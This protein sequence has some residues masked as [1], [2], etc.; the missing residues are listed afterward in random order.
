MIALIATIGTM[1]TVIGNMNM[2]AFARSSDDDQRNNGGDDQQGSSDDRQAQLEK[3]CKKNNQGACAELQGG[4]GQTINIPGESPLSIPFQ[5]S[6]P[7]VR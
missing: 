7:G 4:S 3:A 6:S 2:N 5:H 1:S